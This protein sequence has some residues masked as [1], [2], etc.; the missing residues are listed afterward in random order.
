MFQFLV[1]LVN[2]AL[3]F[4]IQVDFRQT[5]FIEDAYGSAVIDGVLDIVSVD[6][7]A[8]HLGVLTSVPSM[9][10]PVKPMYVAFGNA[11]RMYLAK[12]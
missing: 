5:T 3:A 1:K 6:V 7:V 4:F 2:Q 12:P 10:V 8:K 9:G 11:S